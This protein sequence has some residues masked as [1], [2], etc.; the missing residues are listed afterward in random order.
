MA[1]FKALLFRAGFM[2]FGKLD[3][4]AICDF[5]LVPERTLERWLTKMHHAPAPF[6]CLKC[7]L[8]AACP[9]IAIG[10]SF[11][12]AVTAICGRPAATSTPPNT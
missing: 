7:G 8:L 11:A 4:K 6:G 2:N 5:L 10:A 9:T 3:R 1:D 12:F